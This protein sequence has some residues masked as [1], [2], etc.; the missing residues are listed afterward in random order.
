MQAMAGTVRRVHALLAIA[1]AFAW[2]PLHAQDTEAEARFTA[3]SL[4]FRTALHY[5]PLLDAPLES[6][7]KQYLGA[8]RLDELIALYRSHIGQYPEDAGA[9]TV[10]VRILRRTDRSGADELLAEA[11][12]RHP[13]F[14]PLH[15]LLFRTYEERGDPRAAESLSKALDFEKAGSRRNA[16]LEELLDL[17]EGESARALGKA[18]LVK[19]LAVEGLDG[20]SLLSLARLAQR[21]R[22]WEEALDGL[23][24][25][26][27][28]TSDAEML[29]EIDL[30]QAIALGQLN[31]KAA[32]E[33]LLAALLGRLAPDHWR[34][35]EILSLRFGVLA[36]EEERK[37][38]L[39]SLA[40]TAKAKPDDEAAQLDHGEALLATERRKEAASQFLAA[41]HRLPKSRLL[42]TRAIEVLE[43]EGDLE[44][45]ANLLT[46][47]LELEP[48][49]PDLRFRLV[50]AG[51]ALRRDAAAEQDF[52]T[53]V[54]GL[55]PKAV[56]ERLLELQRYL[57][58]IERLDAAAGYLEQYVRNHPARLDV[59]RELAEVR[60][61]AGATDSVAE[62]V[63]MVSAEEAEAGNVLD[64]AEFLVGA[65]LVQ[66]ARTLVEAKLAVEPRQF[67]LGLKLIGILGKLGDAGAAKER[68]AALRDMTDTA[69]RYRQWLETSIGAHRL[70]ESLPG[71]LDSELNRY[72]FDEASW[73]DE[74]V[75][76]F[77]I[78][79]EAGQRELLAGRV[80]ESLRQQLE[81]DGIEASL[82]L[83][84]RRMLVAVL[85]GDPASVL[86]VEEQ[87]K[88]LAAEDPAHRSEHDLHLALVYQRNERPDLA[89]PL[90]AGIDFD[91][92]ANLSLLREAADGL[93]E[94]G[95]LEEAAKALEVVTS[96]EP[97][98]LLSWELRLSVLAALGEE[99]DLR[100]VVRGL[101]SGEHGVELREQSHRAL[102][103]HLESSFWRS[104]VALLESGRTAEALPLLASLDQEAPSERARLW[105]GWTRIRVLSRLGRETEAREAL[106]RLQEHAAT[107]QIKTIAFPDGLE[108]EL[109]A[110]EQNWN[111][112][113]DRDE[114]EQTSAL[115][116]TEN[117][118]LCWAFE[119][120]DGL[121]VFRVE[122]TAQRVLVLDDRLGLHCLDAANGKLVWRGRFGDD[123]ALH[124]EAALPVFA[125]DGGKPG[126]EPREPDAPLTAKIPPRILVSGERFIL[127]RGRE[128]FAH[129]SE[130][131][132]VVW[133]AA[134]PTREDPAKPMISGR[135][136]P[137][138]WMA[139]ANGRVVLFDAESGDLLGVEETTGKQLWANRLVPSGTARSEPASLSTG[140]EISGDLGIAVGDESVVFNA[141]NGEFVWRFREGPFG[142]F[143][144]VLR[145]PREE[146]TG[147]K[148]S[149]G[150]AAPGETMPLSRF[151]LAA[152]DPEGLG[153]S[154]AFFKGPATLLGP[155]VFW[156]ET[157]RSI[158]APSAAAIDGG[159][160]W[161]MQEEAVRRLSTD[162]PLASRQLAARGSFLGRVGDHAWFLD[163]GELIHVDFHR[164]RSLRLT[165]GDLGTPAELRATLAGNHLVVRDNASVVVVNALTGERLGRAALPTALVEY[166]A[167]M[168]PAAAEGATAGFAWQ[169]R[170]HRSGPGRPLRCLPIGDRISH[171]ACLAAFGNRTVVCLEPSPAPGT[172][173]PPAPAIQ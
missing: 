41:L 110:A 145:P 59:A 157:R 150:G 172:A 105:S 26:K 148:G 107:R 109:A 10:L 88:Q 160:L 123:G 93:V 100:A 116:L 73:P 68:I 126:L 23:N 56:S 22:F 35:R 33:S 83:R 31:Q 69:P 162:L 54:A 124:R 155:A 142:R 98:D 65:G 61:S 125:G 103:D 102:D 38:L 166:L 42:E 119:L 94:N 28:A 67:E 74:K 46:D 133:S 118:E 135:A 14:A 77:L 127:L 72:P 71:F 64:F 50:K 153:L 97:S 43:A 17:S 53:V 55:D 156:S 32:A 91:E 4:R 138:T 62:L 8:G 114:A 3:E 130:D 164:Q 16:W 161:L 1:L 20:P 76:K 34:R 47:R 51:Y 84:L 78:L 137:G 169:G 80:A 63:R 92:V 108:L 58:G 52:R 128:A 101:R 117:P 11:V 27:S 39:A 167:G 82:G 122:R 49:R 168:L 144:V 24:R 2:L 25:A 45:L 120:P 112:K 104:V 70:L 134:L 89:R 86:E 158:E 163:R 60:L 141:A 81:R 87:L 29:V 85:K 151:D 5:D 95:F 9:K 140:L 121:E 44:G 149:G 30:M 159:S 12:P 129:A 21:H 171:G 154:P 15:F 40:A 19:S 165:L 75:E 36:S 13:E 113:S 66:P 79:C 48:D 6:L 139:R 170:L 18:Q 136:S 115:F 152:R 173:V 90:L 143:P 99:S 111:D 131:G 132:S 37:A 106:V 96:L 147:A 57:R 7:V 146:E